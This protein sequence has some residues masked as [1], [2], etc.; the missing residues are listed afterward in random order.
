MFHKMYGWRLFGTTLFSLI[1]L[2]LLGSSENLH[3]L[4]EQE[5]KINRSTENALLAG[6][7]L[8]ASAITGYYLFPFIKKIVQRRGFKSKDS[9]LLA[10]LP[11]LALTTYE[12][13]SALKKSYTGDTSSKEKIDKASL[14]R[15]R[16]FRQTATSTGCAVISVVADYFHSSRQQNSVTTY[17][18]GK[19]SI[20]DDTTVFRRNTNFFL[21]L[22]P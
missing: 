13:C 11:F 20:G 4:R 5:K 12:G 8:S 18:F 22:N 10:G 1:S 19:K 15:D 16:R 6:T 17:T 2:S 9:I 21:T 3:A 14:S 7:H